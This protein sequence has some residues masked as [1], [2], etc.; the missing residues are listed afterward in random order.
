MADIL[1]WAE[2]TAPGYDKAAAV[3]ITGPHAG[4]ESFQR[5]GRML[6]DAKAAAGLA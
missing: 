6:A 3:F 1:V 4:D 5:I 2:V